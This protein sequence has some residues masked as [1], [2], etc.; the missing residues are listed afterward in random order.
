MNCDRAFDSYIALDKNQP[1]PLRISFHLLFCPVC[2]T[3]VRTLTKAEKVLSQA[4]AP[5]YDVP[6]DKEDAIDPS[7]A[8]ALERIQNA[9]LSYPPLQ[10]LVQ[11][12]SM[13]RWLFVGVLLAFGFVF[14]PFSFVGTWAHSAFGEAFAVPFYAA[15][16]LI[17]S[18]YAGLFIGSNI[19]FFVKKFGFHV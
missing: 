15:G 12:V 13:S 11:H 17:I 4:L 19:D 16:G 8:L 7:V 18:V 3:A 10:P 6:L 14:F 1:V 5:V 2:R 9:G